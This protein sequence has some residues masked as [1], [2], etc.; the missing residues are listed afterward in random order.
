M[1]NVQEFH[2]GE[3]EIKT[4]SVVCSKTQIFKK[5]CKKGMSFVNI[6]PITMLGY[7]GPQQYNTA[8]TVLGVPGG[9]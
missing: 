1:T 8:A 4:V 2:S 9:S 5:R 6:Y 7:E 3:G